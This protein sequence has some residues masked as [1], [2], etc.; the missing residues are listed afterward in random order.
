VLL[1]GDKVVNDSPAV[2]FYPHQLDLGE[3]WREMT[4]LPFVYAVWMCKAVRAG[5]PEMKLACEILNHQRLHN[6]TRLGWI[7]SKRASEHG[8]PRNVADDYLSEKLTY[9]VDGEARE[10]IEAFFDRAH[11]NGLIETR[12]ETR[13]LDA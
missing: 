12:R 6:S 1:I 3:S 10:A 5:E 11:A 7:A 4:G 13:W 9:R 2:A 8:W